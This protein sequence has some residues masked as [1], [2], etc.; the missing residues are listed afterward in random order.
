LGADLKFERER[1][2]IAAT[3]IDP[4]SKF[5]S[6]DDTQPPSVEKYRNNWN[7]KSW[8]LGKHLPLESKLNKDDR[9]AT[10]LTPAEM[11]WI[12]VW[13]D[14]VIA[15]KE[16]NDGAQL[17]GFPL[18]VDHWTPRDELKIPKETPEWKINFL[19]KNSD[20]YEANKGIIN[21]WLKSNNNLADFPPSRRKFEWQ[22]QDANNLDE[23]VMHFRPS[24]IRVKKATYL[25]AM[26]AITQTSVLGKQ[27]RRIS[28]REG[29]RLQGLPEWFDFSDQSQTATFKQ[30]GNGVNIGVVYNVMKALIWSIRCT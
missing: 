20:F 3:R 11:N 21:E 29:A 15:Y 6:Q 26:V 18:W 30:L 2:F 27:K 5:D 12:R 9:L 25:P 1:V 10:A 8:R 28:A 23:T 16:N 14:F 4:N 7:I 19:K 22:A 17:P 24:G 13:N